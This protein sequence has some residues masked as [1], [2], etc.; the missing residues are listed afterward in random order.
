MEKCTESFCD[1]EAEICSYHAECE[2]CTKKAV[3]CEDHTNSTC[4]RYGCNEE[5]QYCEDHS[6]ECGNCSQKAT[7]CEDCGKSSCT[8]G[9]NYCSGE[10]D[11]VACSNCFDK[12]KEEELV[13][14]P[15]IARIIEER[16]QDELKKRGIGTVEVKDDGVQVDGMRFQF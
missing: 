12:W 16:V 1:R 9:F 7:L 13:N 4:D 8:V 2:L 5:P 15:I 14:D 6:V 11:F 3:K 10:S